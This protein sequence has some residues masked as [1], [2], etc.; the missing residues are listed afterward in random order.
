MITPIYISIPTRTCTV[1]TGG[2]PERGH[3]GAGALRDGGERGAR[4]GVRHGAQGD[5]RASQVHGA[6]LLVVGEWSWSL[7]VVMTLP[8]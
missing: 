6:S 4:V 2:G 3:A 1:P 5:H 8:S 7:S